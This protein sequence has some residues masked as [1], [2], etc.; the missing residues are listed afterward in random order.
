MTADLLV[1]GHSVAACHAAEAAR[2]A[3]LAGSLVV[4][5][6]EPA[7]NYSRPLI[8][9]YLGGRLGR[10]ELSFRSQAFYDRNRI[11]VLAGRR[12]VALDPA[13]RTVTLADGE[14]LGYRSL[15]L[16][17]GGEP[18]V[19][20]IKGWREGL[21]GVFTFTKLA[22][23]DALAAWLD[24]RGSDDCVV[25]GGGLIGL[26]ATEGLLARGVRPR[27]V[28]LADRVLANTLD[29]EASAILERR[30]A[31]AGCEVRKGRTVAEIR[32]GGDRV[33]SVVLDNG[34]VL[35]ARTLIVA[36]GV[37]PDLRLVR[38]TPMAVER[39]ILVDSRQRTNLAGVYAAGDCAQGPDFLGLK[40]AVIAI[41]PV[42]AR[43][44]RIAGLNAA[45][46]S[47][48]TAG[49]IPM[50]AVQILD[51]PAVSFGVTNPAP[52]GGHE[53]LKRDDQAGGKY[54][55]IV[56]L[57]GRVVG[58]VL[59]GE[60]DRAGLLGTLIRERADVS[61]RRDALLRADLGLL[62][63]PADLRRRLVDAPPPAPLKNSSGPA[64]SRSVR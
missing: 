33:S 11:Q 32:A 39:G 38:E 44:G 3:G 42:A 9:Y 62:D 22:D 60:I 17:T 55:K 48:E 5:G 12:A 53:I 49:A 6:D 41:W 34:E 8:S 7:G 15:L 24:A 16:A 56:L 27:I 47:G 46:A 57:D 50:N 29:R 54:R 59:V 58:V 51:V 1:I 4:V 26:K 25:L 13:A 23:A 10:D 31:V 28:E 19:P 18:I 30:L 2:G 20:P 45:G 40:P 61:D 63:L 14:R 37:K 36:I 64:R 21:G 43:Q 52:G 35:P